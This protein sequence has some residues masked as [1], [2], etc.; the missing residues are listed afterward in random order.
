[1]NPELRVQQRENVVSVSI[2]NDSDCPYIAFVTESNF[3]G[4]NYEKR[5]APF[6]KIKIEKGKEITAARWTNNKFF[7]AA[8]ISSED[9]KRVPK[10]YCIEQD[11]VDEA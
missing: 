2:M 11:V 4:V 8:A 1:M 10:M 9:K 3:S 7:I 6:A 5:S